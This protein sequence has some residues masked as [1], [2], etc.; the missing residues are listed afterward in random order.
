[1]KYKSEPSRKGW[2]IKPA[3]GNYRSGT[4]VTFTAVKRNMSDGWAERWEANVLGHN[5]HWGK[6]GRDGGACLQA[7]SPAWLWNPALPCKMCACV[8]LATPDPPVQNC[9]AS[10]GQRC[11]QNWSQV[12]THSLVS[13]STNPQK[14][15]LEAVGN[16]SSRCEIA[17]QLGVIKEGWVGLLKHINMDVYVLMNLT[18]S[19]WEY[20][21][22]KTILSL[23]HLPGICCMSNFELYLSLFNFRINP[24]TFCYCLHLEP[25]WKLDTR[26]KG[27]IFM[28]GR[29]MLSTQWFVSNVI[30]LP[31]FSR[32]T[33]W[34]SE[35]KTVEELP[36]LQRFQCCESA[37]RAGRSTELV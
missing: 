21:R 7:L 23:G 14:R 35:F 4:Q 22:K 13:T 34:C 30:L 15:H 31:K 33:S 9:L 5:T 10:P 24:L 20:T 17:V 3:C 19:S 25:G 18:G 16:Q 36:K 2:W 29:V 11:C 12:W 27:H 28:N 1:M 6:E 37:A 8:P 32:V 26:Q